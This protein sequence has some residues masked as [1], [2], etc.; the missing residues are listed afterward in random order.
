MKRIRHSSESGLTLI[1]SAIALVVV[2]V[3]FVA[4]TEILDRGVTHSRTGIAEN[5]MQEDARMALTRVFDDVAESKAGFVDTLMRVH[6]VN[7]GS[8]PYSVESDRFTVPGIQLAQCTDPTCKFHT[9]TNLNVDTMRY[10]CGFEYRQ[11]PS[12]TPTARGKIWPGAL[13]HCP[14][15]GTSLAQPARLDGI[16]MLVPRNAAGAFTTTGNG[17]PR[18]SGLVFIFPCASSDGLCELRRYSVYT[19]DLLAVPATVSGTW[20]EF[21]PTDPTM[22]ELLDFGTDGTTDGIRDGSVPR[23]G[24]QSD[25]ATEI[26]TTGTINGQPSIVLMKSL[27]SS[28]NY[29]WRLFSLQINLATGMTSVLAQYYASSG[30]SW[31][32]QRTFQRTPGLVVRHLTEF[33]AS[34]AASSPWS[35]TDNP[36]GLTDPRVLRITLGTSARPN[37]DSDTWQSHIESFTLKTRN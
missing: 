19:S 36:R 37:P 3:G 7:P 27:G 22:V 6:Y 17:D 9:P 18:F 1:E 28:T 35:S 21:S 12:I 25:A 14:L 33:A 32:V 34:T 8:A 29:P 5:G 15:D 4:A 26:F 16:K 2:S 13:A 31:R 30:V 20:T 10:D 11:G 23:T 24:A